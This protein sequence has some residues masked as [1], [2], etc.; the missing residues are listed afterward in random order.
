M[1]FVC[2]EKLWIVFRQREDFMFFP[3]SNLAAG[4]CCSANDPFATHTYCCPT[5]AD[6]IRQGNSAALYSCYGELLSRYSCIFGQSLLLLP[7]SSSHLV[8]VRPLDTVF[9]HFF[10]NQIIAAPQPSSSNSVGAG[11]VVGIVF[12]AIVFVILCL[13]F[14]RCFSNGTWGT[15]TTTVYAPA[16]GYAPG[17]T[18][19][20]LI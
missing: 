15:T 5:G 13:A 1:F 18:F 16:S 11:A 20:R 19:S 9:I 12:G 10:K 3:L 2:T 17:L 8:E 4:K 6:C 7:S 14:A